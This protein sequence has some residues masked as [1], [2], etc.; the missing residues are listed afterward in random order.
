MSPRGK[1]ARLR[2]RIQLFSVVMLL[3]VALLAPA[4]AVAQ[5][6]SP[7]A[8]AHHQRGLQL[9]RSGSFREAAAEFE[10]AER[11]AHSRTNVMNLARC[12]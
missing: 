6:A 2:Q 7:P 12:H 8:E 10:Q 4:A 9:F 1:E 3:G 5:D 11:L